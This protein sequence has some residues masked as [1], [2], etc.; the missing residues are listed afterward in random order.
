MTAPRRCLVV[1]HGSI[2]A[3]HARLLAAAGHEVRLVTSRPAPFPGWPTLDAALDAGPAD[4][5]VVATP[6]ALHH[7]A[8]ETLA[9]RGFSGTTLVEKPHFDRPRP[10][11]SLAGPLRV[12]YNLRFHPAVRELAGM[13]PGRRILSMH[14]YAGQYLPD[15]RPG[16]D[17]A[18][19][20]SARRDLGGGMLRDLSHELDLA[21]HLAGPWREVAARGGHVSDLDMDADDLFCLLLATEGCP[22]VTLQ[23]N[24]L[25]RPGR[26]RL[27]VNTDAF[28]A[29][30]DLVGHTLCVG[31][32]TR[33]FDVPSDTTYMAQ[34]RDVLE[35][36][37]VA[38]TPDQALAVVDL[39][40]AAERANREKIWVTP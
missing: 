14:L 12:A 13:L 27:V 17:Y 8:L 18:A 39:I 21:C 15:W 1:G 40:Q 10:L 33:T 9:R 5:V 22:A 6:T 20:Y 29:E 38:C 3:R 19:C 2:G 36:G 26:R 16:R 23:I 25:D 31:R 4:Y 11:P 28:T 34:H 24:C 37:G 32:D 35:N 7:E 30:L